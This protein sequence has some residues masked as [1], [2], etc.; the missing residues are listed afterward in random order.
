MQQKI[1]T[2]FIQRIH[3][4]AQSSCRQILSSF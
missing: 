4:H 3:S 1:L 2:N